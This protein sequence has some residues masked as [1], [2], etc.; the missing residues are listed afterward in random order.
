[1]TSKVC[2]GESWP[3]CLWIL[4]ISIHFVGLKAFKMLSVHLYSTSSQGFMRGESW[5]DRLFRKKSLQWPGFANWKVQASVGRQY[6]HIVTCILP[7]PWEDWQHHWMV[8]YNSFSKVMSATIGVSCGSNI[9]SIDKE[10][11]CSV[12][13]AHGHSAAFEPKCASIWVGA[14]LNE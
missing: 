9:W 3:G 7:I 13:L 2:E 14:S 10:S 12:K 5:T 4:L 6:P 11:A 8:N 1:M